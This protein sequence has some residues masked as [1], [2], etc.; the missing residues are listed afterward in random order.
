MVMLLLTFDKK[1]IPNFVYNETFLKTILESD[2]KEI[3][4]IFT[5][6]LD[7][8]IG[9]YSAVVEKRLNHG[10]GPDLPRSYYHLD[11]N[12]NGRVDELTSQE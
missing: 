7:R 8:L 2:H 1:K 4:C 3:S 6:N 5:L 10:S 12:N 9:D 11:K